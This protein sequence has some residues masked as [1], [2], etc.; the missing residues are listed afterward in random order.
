MPPVATVRRDQVPMTATVSGYALICTGYNS[1]GGCTTSKCAWH[2]WYLDTKTLPLLWPLAGLL[3]AVVAITVICN[4][5]GG[6]SAV[7]SGDCASG[8]GRTTAT[9]N[10]MTR[11]AAAARLQWRLTG[12]WFALMWPRGVVRLLWPI[13]GYMYV[14]AA[15]PTLAPYLVPSGMTRLAPT[16]S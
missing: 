1:S 12:F 8:A 2:D 6:Q 13:N 7:S 11:L 3:I 10:S 4:Y 9:A 15:K 14:M 16:A 5:M